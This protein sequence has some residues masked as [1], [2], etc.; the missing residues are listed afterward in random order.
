MVVKNKMK[1]KFEKIFLATVVIMMPAL[2]QAYLPSARTV[3]SRTVEN[4]GSGIYQIEQEITFPTGSMESGNFIVLERWLVKSEDEMHLTVRGTGEHK[5]TIFFERLYKSGRVYFYKNTEN[6]QTKISSSLV[7]ENF[8]EKFFHYRS[9]KKLMQELK[10]QRLLPSNYAFS[11]P[12]TDR[13]DDVLY[14]HEPFARLSRLGGVVCYAYGKPSNKNNW[15]P[16]L[17]I[18]QDEFVL[19]KL[20][21]KSGVEL[22]ASH[23]NK[24]PKKFYMPKKYSIKSKDHQYKVQVIFV[25]SKKNDHSVRSK[26]SHQGLSQKNQLDG[27]ET[28]SNKKIVLDFYERFR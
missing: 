25:K 27:L 21:L 13:L 16:G 15:F 12:T 26:L 18:A 2:T 1:N 17:W 24:Y 5:N 8:I 23:Y 7:P 28:I 22:V 14:A 4:N 11:Q 19:R 9:E 10:K 3:L 20:R 6:K